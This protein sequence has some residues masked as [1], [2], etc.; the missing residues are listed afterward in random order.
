LQL[1]DAVPEDQ[2][3]SQN[4]AA[5]CTYGADAGVDPKTVLRLA[6]AAAATFPNDYAVQNTLGAALLR[7]GRPAEAIPRLEDAMRRRD[8]PES[9]FDEL[10]LA[11]AYHQL[12]DDA[13]G[14]R[15]LA[16]A[17]QVLDEY[18]VPAAA[19]GTLGV[20]PLGVLPAAA[21]LLAERPDPREGKD[22]VSLCNWL[23]MGILRA[24]AEAAL[25]KDPS[26]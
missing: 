7:V 26:R 17:S 22:D 15:W 4:V 19:C 1:A 2:W 20:A 21:A 23:E 12:G 8:R 5:V 25:A 10:L 11:L 14:R 13:N 24:E 18:R 3:L 9:V 6:E 16:R